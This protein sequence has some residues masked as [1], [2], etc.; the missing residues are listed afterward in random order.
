MSEKNNSQDTKDKK[1]PIT[2]EKTNEKASTSQS[3]KTAHQDK[4]PDKNTPPLQK[5]ADSTDKKSARTSTPSKTK[6]GGFAKFIMFISFGLSA[7]A[8]GGGYWLW[9]QL[10]LEQ[11]RSQQ[12]QASIQQSLDE[13]VNNTK[14]AVQGAKDEILASNTEKLSQVE[15][16]IKSTTEM[17]AT[18]DA[19][20]NNL[21]ERVGNTSRDWVVA[22]AK[23]I[24]Q[25]ANHRLRLERDVATATAAL[26][27][28]DE[29]IKSLGEPALLDVRDLLAKEITQLETFPDPDIAGKALMINQLANEV[30]ALPLKANIQKVAFAKEISKEPV[31]EAD[32]IDSLPDAILKSIKG[33]IT[34]RHNE[35]PIEPLL[36]PNQVYNL[37]E[38]L[39][40]KLEQTHLALLQQNQKLFEENLRVAIE[41][42]K[43][44]FDLEKTKASKFV[45][46]LEGLAQTEIVPALPDI[47]NS[48]RKLNAIANRLDLDPLK[49]S[50][51]GA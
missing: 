43:E 33:L 18:F 3:A 11:T 32:T 10:V 39:Q 8:V 22:E 46:Q 16:K 49:K 48:L 38:N 42:T 17:Q 1:E 15:G 24:M 31:V 21:L 50:E 14:Q 36:T 26:K 29:R 7:T 2:A 19:R 20:M 4:K 6:I 30:T 34:V 25:I 5:K 9:Q 23:Y 28:A 37:H 40:L 41:W 45:D 44:F 35:R 47:S 27:L 51:G 13:T 12:L